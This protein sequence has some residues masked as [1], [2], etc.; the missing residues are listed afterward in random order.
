ME[1]RALD[2]RAA[3]GQGRERKDGPLSRKSHNGW[4]FLVSLDEQHSLGNSGF[5]SGGILD[6]NS[7]QYLYSRSISRRTDQ[8]AS[9]IC[10]V[11]GKRKE[12]N[13]WPEGEIDEDYK[14]AR[15]LNCSLFICLGHENQKKKERKK[16][17]LEGNYKVTT[18]SKQLQKTRD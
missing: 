9:S 7:S 14:M 1:S 16:N 17:R 15:I 8:W 11:S 4:F 12:S 6:K 5:I 3:R 10:L 13:T 2:H 18:P